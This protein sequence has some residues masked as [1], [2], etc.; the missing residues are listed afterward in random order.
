MANNY[1]KQV[2][3]AK[4]LF[5]KYDQQEMIQKLHLEHD[6]TYLY[7]TILNRTCRILRQDGKIEMGSTVQNT[8]SRSDVTAIAQNA[9]TL[10]GDATWEESLDYNLVMTI[11][12]ALCYPKETPLLAH[13][14]A[15]LASLQVTMSSPSADLFTRKYADF[16]SGKTEQLMLACQELGGRKPDTSAGADVCWEFDFFPNFPIQFRF[17][18]KDEEFPPQIRLLWDKNSLRFMHFETLYYA[19]HVLLEELKKA[20]PVHNSQNRHI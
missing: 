13:Q 1:D 8:S 14:W 12:D 3:T 19:L 10:S 6:D 17:W 16:F 9:S 4:Q 20:M 11:Y 7:L 2:L 15:P 18:D 5:L